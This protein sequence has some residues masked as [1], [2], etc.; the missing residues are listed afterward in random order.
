MHHLPIT[1]SLFG[2]IR[3]NIDSLPGL[4]MSKSHRTAMDLLLGANTTFHA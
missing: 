3:E 2:Y 4:R 1:V